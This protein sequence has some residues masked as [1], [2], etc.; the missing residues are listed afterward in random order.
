MTKKRILPSFLAMLV[1]ISSFNIFAFA[2]TPIVKSTMISLPNK[3]SVMYIKAGQWLY[4]NTAEERYIDSSR[5]EASYVDKLQMRP[6]VSESG[7]LTSKKTGAQYDFSCVL[8]DT[9]SKSA[10]I[11]TAD[12]YT[13]NFENKN[14]TSINFVATTRG[15]QGTKQ[16]WAGFDTE[17]Y[18]VTVKYADDTTKDFTTTIY[19]HT[20][21]NDYLITS[22]KCV[23]GYSCAAHHETFNMFEY[24]IPVDV[25]KQ[26][27]SITFEANQNPISVF[28]ISGVTDVKAYIESK[29]EKLPDSVSESNSSEVE[30]LLSEISAEIEIFEEKGGKSSDISNIAKYDALKASF[31]KVESVNVANDDDSVTVTAV[32]SV[33]MDNGTIGAYMLEGEDKIEAIT[34]TFTDS[35]GKTTA[36][37]KFKHYKNYDKAHT[38]V[39]ESGAKAISNGLLMLDKFSKAITLTPVFGVTKK[40]FVTKDENNPITDLSALKGKDIIVKIT[41][42]EPTLTS[43]KKYI[44]I[45]GL[46]GENNI[47]KSCKVI[48]D[49]LT[50]DL[51]TNEAKWELTLPDD[52]SEK[53][54]I[55]CFVVDFNGKT[56]FNPISLK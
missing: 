55:K 42:S 56:L 25:S 10:R 1:I 19:G 28:A 17:N 44:V 21:N 51:K 14:Y 2:D 16:N 46:Y 5:W 20:A 4:G 31:P 47:L 26:I 8:P 52:V 48:S 15:Q 18:K 33:A 32:F 37:L 6:L 54:N 41:L 40:E 35:E 13:V 24:S 39:V 53:D 22:T 36:V 38:F 43:E 50:E 34:K 3:N 9:A 7:I 49:K 27:T 11:V 45:M 12:G 30:I 29:I 23:C